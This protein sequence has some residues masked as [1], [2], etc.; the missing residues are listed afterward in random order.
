[1]LAAGSYTGAAGVLDAGTLELLYVL[2][3]HKGGITQVR[4]WALLAVR[5][6]PGQH[7]GLAWLN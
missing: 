1:M 7:C 2:H 6:A 5:G 3:G 4:L